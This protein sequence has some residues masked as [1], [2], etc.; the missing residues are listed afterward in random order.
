MLVIA[1]IVLMLS[2][3]AAN[4]IFGIRIFANIIM[5]VFAGTNTLFYYLICDRA[6][7]PIS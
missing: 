3:G 7:K 4:G 2:K 5:L 1:L 6:L